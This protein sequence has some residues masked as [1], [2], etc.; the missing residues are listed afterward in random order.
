LFYRFLIVLQYSYVPLF[1]QY[2]FAFL[3]DP[4]RETIYQ[5]NFPRF[6]SEFLWP[7]EGIT[8]VIKIVMM[9]AG[10]QTVRFTISFF[11]TFFG[12]KTF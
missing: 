5:V 3:R 10:F 1:S 7:N 11:E 8:T 12:R 2:L 9:L 4:L 6:V